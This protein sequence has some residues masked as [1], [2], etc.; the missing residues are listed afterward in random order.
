MSQNPDGND[1]LI[2]YQPPPEDVL[3]G[4]DLQFGQEWLHINSL[5]T[6][7]AEGITAQEK[8]SNLED[9]A[10]AKATHHMLTT[11]V[12]GDC[13]AYFH[14]DL[15]LLT[16]RAAED[17]WSDEVTTFHLARLV[18]TYNMT[19][20]ELVAELQRKQ[21]ASIHITSIPK[22]TFR[23]YHKRQEG[24]LRPFANVYIAA[25]A[26]NGVEIK[27]TALNDGGNDNIAAPLN[28]VTIRVEPN[29][30]VA[31]DF[32]R[33]LLFPLG[34]ELQHH[35]DIIKEF[36][37]K[38]V[39]LIG[40]FTNDRAGFDRAR[41]G[42]DSKKPSTLHPYVFPIIDS[43]IRQKLDRDAFGEIFRALRLLETEPIEAILRLKV[44]YEE[45]LDPEAYIQQKDYYK[46]EHAQDLAVFLANATTELTKLGCVFEGN[47]I[48][49]LPAI[50]ERIQKDKRYAASVISAWP[51][52]FTGADTNVADTLSQKIEQWLYIHQ[53]NLY[54]RILKQALIW[55]RTPMTVAGNATG[56][57]ASTLFFS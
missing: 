40:F 33:E 45:L 5:L 36:K 29:T 54:Y 13:A 7:F 34:S 44:L 47:T 11:I 27:L 23:E 21:M 2:P 19:Q 8:A 22:R 20:E 25:I 10:I 31:T 50:V 18:D 53:I 52:I 39:E 12:Q 56:R 28:S 3:P 26:E 24:T 15:Q 51:R 30:P 9:I 46:I 43:Y 55:T 35:P 32:E 49:N 1:G 38:F 17:K 16:S 42:H 57:H 14:E 37:H 48:T 6:R 41:N 4:G